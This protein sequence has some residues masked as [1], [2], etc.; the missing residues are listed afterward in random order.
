MPITF[1]N[2]SL[3]WPNGTPCF[4]DLSGAFTRPMTGLIGDNGTGKSSLLK[5]LVGQLEPTSGTMQTPD[6]IAYL[7]QDLGLDTASTIADIFG[8]T[9][10]LAAIAKVEA[11]EYAPELLEIIGEN[12]D[13]AEA[14]TVRLAEVGLELKLDRTVGTLSGGE[15]VSVALTAAFFT[16]PDFLVLDEPTNNLDSQAKATLIKLVT[17]SQVPVLVVSHDRDLLAHTTQI[18]ELYHGQLRFFDGNYATYREAIDQEQAAAVQGVRE[19]KAEERKQVREREAMQT[20]LARDARR[21]RKFAAEKRKPPIAM[22]MDKNK[23]E[24]SSSKREM[25][26]ADSVAQARDNFDAAQRKVRDSDQ[27][28]IDLPATRL[29]NGTRALAAEELTIVGPERVRIAGPNGSGKTT[30]LNAIDRGEVEYVI[31]ARGYL[32]QRIEL[33]PTKSVLALVL[34]ANPETDPQYVR[35]QLAQLLFRND[36]VRAQVGT[37]SGGE[38]FRIEFARVLLGTPAPQLLLIDEPT[39]NLDISTVDWLV[40]ALEGYQGALIVVSHDDDFCDRIGIE[41]VIEL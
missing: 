10:I 34:D 16:N 1:Q 40:S 22:G 24:R 8:I 32:R 41:R 5:V 38:R 35:N 20:R 23:S 31:A 30:L 28:F 3:T 26:A 29:A 4:T 2:L 19:A 15:A 37:L 39:N 18:A 9:P 13:V 21:G 11:G 33:D 6:N 25:A 14:V 12:W 36:E 17:H 27:V 7:P